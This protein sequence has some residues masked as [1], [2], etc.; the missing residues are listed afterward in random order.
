MVLNLVVE[1]T[2]ISHGKCDVSFIDSFGNACK[3]S[4][5]QMCFGSMLVCEGDDGIGKQHTTS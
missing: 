1:A 5:Y 3:E 2:S 4:H